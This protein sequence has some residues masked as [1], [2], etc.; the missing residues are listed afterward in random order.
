MTFTL[1]G[2][3]RGVEA[4]EVKWGILF[5][6]VAA[7]GILELSRSYVR[8]IAFDVEVVWPRNLLLCLELEQAVEVLASVF[9][10]LT[11]DGTA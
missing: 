3:A 11:H 7:D 8:M 10:C 2:I 1:L 9:V 6:H 5:R 4:T